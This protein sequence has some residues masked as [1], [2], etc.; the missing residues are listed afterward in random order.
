MN[1]IGLLLQILAG[2][3]L[4]DFLSGLL[5]WIED[6][7]GPGREHWPVVGSQVFAPNLLH[8]AQPLAFTR[9]RFL[10]RNSTTIAAAAVFAA[11]L[12]WFFGFQPWLVVA[13]IGL[14]IWWIMSGRS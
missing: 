12:L 10:S 9:N 14:A 8:H 13:A 4:A 5:H 2:W 6:R 11:P 7:F 3:L 1:A